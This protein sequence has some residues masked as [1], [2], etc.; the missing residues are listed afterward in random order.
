LSVLR[1]RPLKSPTRAF[2]TA[3]T[4]CCAAPTICSSWSPGMEVY[5]SHRVS[6][7]AC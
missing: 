2:L 5:L 7:R 3:S 4:G 6:C 1:L